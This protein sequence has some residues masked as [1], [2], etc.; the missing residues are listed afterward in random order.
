MLWSSLLLAGGCAGGTTGTSSD[1]QT[2]AGPNSGAAASAAGSDP[3][4]N[5]GTGTAQPPPSLADAGRRCMRYDVE[6]VPQIPTVFVLVDRSGTMF[7][8]SAQG[9]VAW[10]AL[11]T[12]VLQVIEELQGEV[13]FGFGAFTGEQGQTC[14]FWD[15]VN[16]NLNNHEA[17]ASVYTGLSRPVKGET[18]TTR[19]LPL[20]RD[21]LLGDPTPGGKYILFATDGEPDYCSDGNALCPIDSVVRSLQDLSAQGITTFVFGLTTTAIP[22]PTGTLAAWANAGRAMPVQLFSNNGG[23]ALTTQ[24]L[25][26]Q[27]NVVPDWAA[28]HAA[29]GRAMLQPLGNYAATG[30]QA[31]VF[32]PNLAD[33]AALTAQLRSLVHGLKS[34][35]FD[36][37]NR[38]KV[39]VARAGEA[40]V[41]VQDTRIDYDATGQN[42]WHMVTPTQLALVGQACVLWQAPTST[43]IHFDFPCEIILPPE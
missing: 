11:Q 17:I 23:G 28:Q 19:A 41:T 33:Q 6:F 26:Y 40:R 3:F 34:C 16:P 2:G 14:P 21:V 32:M 20:A 39:D 18:P 7:D 12:A 31:E 5:A 43:A 38:I 27:C 35:T 25:Y 42:G 29:L 30:G 10:P 36:L 22:V 13:R 1:N 9:V 24:D 8:M 37:Q 15:A 4:A